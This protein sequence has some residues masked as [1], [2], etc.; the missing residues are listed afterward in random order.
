MLL[1]GLGLPRTGKHAA[2]AWAACITCCWQVAGLRTQIPNPGPR[3]A[4][5]DVIP[6][7]AGLSASWCRKSQGYGIPEEQDSRAPWTH[8]AT[9][10]ERSVIDQAINAGRGGGLAAGAPRRPA[11]RRGDE[12]ALLLLALR[13]LGQPLQQAQGSR[14]IPR[15]QGLGVGCTRLLQAQS[16]LWSLIECVW[17]SRMCRAS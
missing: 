2:Q 11:A 12:Q 17:S 8:P 3:L 4:C 6:C 13:G 14:H 10:W 9:G 7:W 1:R 5:N 16:Q 15:Q